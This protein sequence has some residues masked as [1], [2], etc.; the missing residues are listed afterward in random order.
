MI[1]AYKYLNNSYA[2][3]HPKFELAEGKSK[4]TRGNGMKLKKSQHRRGTNSKHRNHYFTEKIFEEW[5]SLPEEVVKAPSLNAFKNRL[6][7]HWMNRKE[8]F[9]PPCLNL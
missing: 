5:N 8:R 7:K 3:E 2:V 6:D 4:D 9:N 1:E